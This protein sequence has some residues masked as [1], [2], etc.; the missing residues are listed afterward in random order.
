[1]SWLGGLFKKKEKVEIKTIDLDISELA[2]WYK[3]VSKD[4]ITII[5]QKI[6]SH[7]EEIE[8]KKKNA[9]EKLD[10]LEK[11]ELKNKNIPVKEIQIMQGN[12]DAYIKITNQFIESLNT[13]IEL[14]YESCKDFCDSFK[15]GLKNLREST[16]RS[17]SVLMHFFENEATKVTK[18]INTLI[19]VISEIEDQIDGNLKPI[20]DV[21][22]KITQ[23]NKEIRTQ[24]KQGDELEG[25]KTNLN[26]AKKSLEK[27]DK[28]LEQLL[29]SEE[30]KNVERL[31]NKKDNI[32]NEL[33]QNDYAIIN[34]FSPLETPLKKLERVSIDGNALIEKYAT[35][36]TAAL[37]EDSELKIMQFLTKLSNAI[38]TEQIDVR[39]KKKEKALE[40]I[41]KVNR[42]QLYSYKTR[43]EQLK[44]TQ[45]EN[46][47]TLKNSRIG[48]DIDE[49]EYRKEHLR[50]KIKRLE[51]KTAT[52]EK[53]LEAKDIE[54]IKNSITEDAEHLFN[55]KI[56]I[57]DDEADN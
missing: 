50:D 6:K 22:D 54:N 23:L 38:N 47:R 28:E 33:K 31:K 11:E 14:S 48:K 29:K 32:L 49:C 1:M 18:E 25:D 45:L 7:L 8:V 20:L 52:T 55:T 36:P 42:D 35:N 37:E 2:E 27:I 39:D 17:Y 57:K 10:N 5:K 21:E 4:E 3:T 43:R 53:K 19:N 40:A 9:K 15:L 34:I 51:D 41:E 13:N 30:F 44:Q 16:K 12:K 24:F 26:K 56:K 46:E